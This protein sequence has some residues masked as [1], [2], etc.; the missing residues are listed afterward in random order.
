MNNVIQEYL[1]SLKPYINTGDWSKATGQIDQMVQNSTDKFNKYQKD[2]LS[3]TLKQ[4]EINQ[5]KN[6]ISDLTKVYQETGDKEIESKINAYKMFLDEA[7]TGLDGLTTNLLKSEASL[8]SFDKGIGSVAGGMS[9]AAG[10]ITATISTLQM[11]YEMAGKLAESA[12]QYSN[13]FVS[14]GS[15]FLDPSV[16]GLMAKFGTSAVDAQ[17]IGSTMGVMGINEGDFATMLPGQR[18]AFDELMNYYKAGIEEIDPDKLERFNEATQQFQLMQA[19]FQLDMKTTIMDL[20]ANNE[21]LPDMMD[22]LGDT[23]DTIVSILGSPTAQ[24]AF[25]TFTAFLTTLLDVLN[26]AGTAIS[27]IMGGNKS[28]NIKIDVKSINNNNVTSNN[29]TVREVSMQ[30]ENALRG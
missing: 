4:Q 8:T 5:Y 23:F 15:M 2:K 6:T 17:A 1:Y 27:W 10:V 7:E 30:L 22:A 20:F 29:N 14:S 3:V 24:F 18:K 11:A 21:K 12:K 19:K 25:N 28:N 9:K 26:G 13:Q 16:K